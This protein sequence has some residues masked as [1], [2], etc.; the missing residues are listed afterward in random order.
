M[1]HHPELKTQTIALQSRL[2][3]RDALYEGRTKATRLHYKVK[4]GYSFHYVDVMSV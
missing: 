1:S 3:T 4:E 2:I